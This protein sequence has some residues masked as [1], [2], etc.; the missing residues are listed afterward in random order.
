MGIS[1]TLNGNTVTDARLFI[2][3]WGASWHDVTINGDVTL[4]GAV[5]LVVADLTIQGTVMSGG[6]SGKGRSFYRIVAG[7]GGWGK[8]LPAVSYANDA[9]VKLSKVFNDVASAAGEKINPASIPS[10]TVG[11]YFTRPADIASRVLEQLSPS[12][13]YVDETGTT[14]I[15]TRPASTL[16]ATAARVTLLDLARGT[17]TLA[18]DTIAGILPGVTVDGL[19]AI[20]VEHTI[21]PKE[22]LRTKL[23]GR[24]S[25][26]A[27]RRLSAFRAIVDQLDPDRKFRGTYE[28]R[29]VTQNGT[30]LNLQ[31][32]STVVGMPTLSNV[33][34]RPGVAGCQAQ[35]HL[36]AR[37]IVGFVNADPGRPVVIAFED[38][39]GPGFLS[40]AL[41]IDAMTSVAV[42][43]SATS[44]AVAGSGS[45]IARLG[46][47][48]MVF[49]PPTLPV[50]G[51][52]SGSPFAGVITVV[53]PI[54]GQI[55]AGSSKATSG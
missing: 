6:P 29:I 52:V 30:R 50:A 26:S 10:G 32:V 17:L 20:D 45:P 11:S 40:T 48:V 2:P 37:V 53:N 7:A 9:G 23:W 44:V 25:T 28:Y 14:Q 42:G 4:S 16:A 21:D 24:A 18:S 33:M 34:V 51:T 49:L 15:G 1:A 35:Y 5:T 22:G 3:G 31:P 41:T 54:T 38:A 12:A 8:E 39:D 43:P 47:Q 36:G 46:D 13:W 27:S 19:T 55:V